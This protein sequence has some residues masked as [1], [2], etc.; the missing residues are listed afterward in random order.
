MFHAGALYLYDCPVQRFIPIYL[1]VGGSF[2]VYANISG[3]IQTLC[4]K[5]V[6]DEG[7]RVALTIFCKISESLVGCFV[8]A[9]IIAGESERIIFNQ[10]FLPRNAL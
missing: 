7:K 5:R 6:T 4:H 1:V 3:L 9:W 8:I 10:S 2:S